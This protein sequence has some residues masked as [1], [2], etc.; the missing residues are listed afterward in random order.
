MSETKPDN[1]RRNRGLDDSLNPYTGKTW[2]TWISS[3]RIELALRKPHETKTLAYI[4]PGVLKAPVA[5]FREGRHG[6]CYVGIPDRSYPANLGGDPAQPYKDQV[7]LVFVDEEDNNL[8]HQWEWCEADANNP[9]LPINHAAR[10]KER[11]L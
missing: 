1:S 3:N 4:V 10:F 2:K 9:T 7:F 6:L 11:I 8:I 5:V